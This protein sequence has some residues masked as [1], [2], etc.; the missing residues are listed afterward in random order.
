[1][2]FGKKTERQNAKRWKVIRVRATIDILVLSLARN[3]R[4]LGTLKVAK[5]EMLM[6]REMVFIEA[7]KMIE[8]K[9]KV[10]GG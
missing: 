6:E 1:M 3:W 8:M 2:R 7:L 5:M 10:N 9:E 4:L